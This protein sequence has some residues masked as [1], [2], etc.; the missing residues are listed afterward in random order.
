MPMAQVASK[1]IFHLRPADGAIGSHLKGVQEA[2]ENF[3]QL[4][5]EIARRCDVTLP[6]DEI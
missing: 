4:A 2:R 6:E 3:R 5:V 1:P